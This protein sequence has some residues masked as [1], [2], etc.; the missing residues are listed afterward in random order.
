MEKEANKSEVD[1]SK[2]STTVPEEN[3]SRLGTVHVEERLNHSVP[4]PD[5]RRHQEDKPMRNEDS[6]HEEIHHPN[7]DQ[8]SSSETEKETYLLG[9][10]GLAASG[11][12]N[13]RFVR[14]FAKI[15][16]FKLRP[17]F[18]RNYS[19]RETHTVNQFNQLFTKNFDDRTPDDMI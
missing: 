16:E 17:F 8:D 19:L 2:P 14:W 1:R 13:S 4:D 6:D 10:N 9:K 3:K 11:F 7:L 15:D 18:I 12:A 5:P